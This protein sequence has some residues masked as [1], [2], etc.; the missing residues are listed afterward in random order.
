MPSQLALP[1]RLFL[2]WKYQLANVHTREKMQLHARM[3]AFMHATA[4]TAGVN[5]GGKDRCIAACASE[6]MGSPSESGRWPWLTQSRPPGF[7][8]SADRRWPSRNPLPLG[9]PGCLQSGSLRHAH[10][11]GLQGQCQCKEWER[12]C[13]AA[14]CKT[15]TGHQLSQLYLLARGV[16][17]GHRCCHK[18]NRAAGPLQVH[19]SAAKAGCVLSFR[20]RRLDATLSARG[21]FSITLYLHSMM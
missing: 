2:L 16:Q 17:T 7:A 18:H 1:I 4:L 20:R 5:H 9:V 8:A 14:E 3:H 19:R 15:E 12:A 10:Q 13:A 11:Q 6:A 21:T